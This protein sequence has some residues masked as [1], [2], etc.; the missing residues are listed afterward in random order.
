MQKAMTMGGLRP[1]PVIRDELITQSVEYAKTVSSL[2]ESG[3][4]LPHDGFMWRILGCEAIDNSEMINWGGIHGGPEPGLYHVPR[5][6][7]FVFSL[8]RDAE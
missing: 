6:A 4:A 1:K 8:E 2:M 5:P 3:F 7:T